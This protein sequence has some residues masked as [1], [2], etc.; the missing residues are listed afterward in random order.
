[1]DACLERACPPCPSIPPPPRYGERSAGGE[2]PIFVERKVHRDRYTGEFRW[3]G[4]EGGAGN[5]E[6]GGVVPWLLGQ[7]GATTTTPAAELI[8]PRLL[9]PCPRSYKERAPMAQRHVEAYTGE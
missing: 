4:T 7:R 1:M 3:G 9:P 5:S 8:S 6:G 2:Q